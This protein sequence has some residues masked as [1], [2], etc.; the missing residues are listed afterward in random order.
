MIR[1]VLRLLVRIHPPSFRRAHGQE[2][3][4]DLLTLLEGTEGRTGV[5]ALAF[6]LVLNTM[7]R[8]VAEWASVGAEAVRNLGGEVWEMRPN[9]FGQDVRFAFRGLLRDPGFALAAVVTI[10][11]GVGLTTTVFGP[12]N[13]V[14][15][16]PLSY[17]EAD[18]LQVISRT[19][20]AGG[21]MNPFMSEPDLRD[22]QSSARSFEGLFGY[23]NTGMT[24]T[25][26]GDPVRISGARV[27]D[28]I[29]ALLGLEP[30][31]GRDLTSEEALLDGPDV[32]VIG[33]EFW[34]TRLGGDPDVLGRTLQLNGTPRKVIGVAPPG[35]DFPGEAE[36]WVPWHLDV[37]GCGR[38]CH[39]MASCCWCR[40]SPGSFPRSGP[41]ALPSSRP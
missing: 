40:S 15:L 37:E 39:T 4:R 10:G 30:T 32:I 38:G 6:A 3:Q 12:V 9:T 36:F 8:L 14:L 2:L 17:P 28:P 24:L 29:L 23:G 31:L 18:A 26:L 1:L 34:R 41:R 27:T 25:G 35:F 13:G 22:L 7:W 11:L 5:S 21:A 33:H 19:D 16:Q 20:R